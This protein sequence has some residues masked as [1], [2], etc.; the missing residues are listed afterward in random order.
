VIAIGAGSS[1]SEVEEFARSFHLTFPIWVD[2]ETAALEAFK[3]ASLPNSYVIDRSG[4]VR[5]AWV[6]EIDRDSLEKHVTPLLSE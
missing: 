1:A 4:I 2:T 5:L 6:G 3:N